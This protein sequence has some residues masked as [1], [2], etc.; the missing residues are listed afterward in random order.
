MNFLKHPCLGQKWRYLLG[1]DKRTVSHSFLCLGF[2]GAAHHH[3]FLGLCHFTS[4][5]SLPVFLSFSLILTYEFTF[6]SIYL[7]NNQLKIFLSENASLKITSGY[8]NTSIKLTSSKNFILHILS[9]AYKYTS[10]VVRFSH[11]NN[12]IAHIFLLATM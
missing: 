6:N 4:L 11:Q 8:N 12:H 3:R 1:A 9:V 5:T 7:F 10:L 2:V